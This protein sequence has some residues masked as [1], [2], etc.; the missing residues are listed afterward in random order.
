MP[1]TIERLAKACTGTWHGQIIGAVGRGWCSPEN[2]GKEMD[3]DLANAITVEVETLLKTDIH[4]KLG[5]ATT[6]QLIDEL[7]ARMD[8]DLSYRTIDS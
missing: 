5:C 6:Q 4:P 8:I 2:S 7:C 1:E 3:Y